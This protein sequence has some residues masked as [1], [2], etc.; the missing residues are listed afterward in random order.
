MRAAGEVRWC[1]G[2]RALWTSPSSRRRTSP[3]WTTGDQRR[4]MADMR[5][6]DAKPHT[7]VANLRSRRAAK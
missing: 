4:V 3:G 6:V 7:L 1:H 2:P 5:S